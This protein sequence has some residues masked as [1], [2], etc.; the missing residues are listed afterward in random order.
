M[1][2]FSLLVPHVCLMLT[3]CF[4]H[5]HLH[6]G[7][8]MFT[9]LSSC[10]YLMLYMCYYKSIYRLVLITQE[11][12]GSHDGARA[13]KCQFWYPGSC[14][15]VYPNY[16]L[17]CK[18]TCILWTQQ[19]C[20]PIW[21]IVS[22][23][24]TWTSGH[25]LYL[26]RSQHRQIFWLIVSFSLST[27]FTNHLNQSFQF[28][29]PVLRYPHIATHPWDIIPILKYVP[30]WIPGAKIQSE[31]AMMQKHATLMHTTVCSDRGIIGMWFITFSQ[32]LT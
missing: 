21:D 30:E 11:M 3:T 8:L 31:A 4:P 22:F 1:L 27:F 26:K 10:V 20:R 2:L 15:T 9:L 23:R 14:P 16:L 17:A 19:P 7:L 5:W 18:D 28:N 12:L 13:D 25:W 32:I 6:C 29:L 24:P